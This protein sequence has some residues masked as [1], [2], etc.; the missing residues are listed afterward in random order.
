MSTFEIDGRVVGGGNVYVIAEVAQ[1][2]EGSLGLAH[3][4]IDAAA[5]AGVDAVKFQTHLADAES[6]RDEQFRVAF[7]DQDATRFDYWRRMEF[8]GDEWVGLARHAHDRGL[9]FFSSPFSPEAIDLLERVGVPAWKV[10]SGEVSNLALLDR[11]AAT[12][13]PVILSSGMSDYSELDAAVEVLRDRSAVAVLQCTTAYPVAPDQIG[14]NILADLRSRYEFPVGLSDH[15]GTI[16]PSLAAVALGAALIEVHVTLSRR[17]FGPDVS[18]SLTPEELAQLVT[19]TRFIS[20]ALASPVDKD[21]A[22]RELGELRTLFGRSVAPVR[23]LEAG[24][25]LA[26]SDLTLKKP[27]SGIPPARLESLVGR[28]LSRSIEADELL[29]EDDLI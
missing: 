15:S 10:G 14:L 24:T 9:A 19:G 27:G 20:S 21:S 2:H 16:Y 28:T 18:A 11:M 22:A 3:A 13:L 5:D 1:G 25:V 12:G 8:T 23:P 29:R 6:T 26:A 17:M 4:H 7:S